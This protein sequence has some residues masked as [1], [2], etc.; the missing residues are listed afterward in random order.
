MKQGDS[1]LSSARCVILMG[2]LELCVDLLVLDLGDFDIVLGMVWL[3]SWHA[4]IDYITKGVC[5]HPPGQ[6]QFCF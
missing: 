6:S 1:R 4:I 3:T 5:F 2:N